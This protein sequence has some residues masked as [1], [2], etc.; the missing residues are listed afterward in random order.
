[1]GYVLN[2]LVNL[3][4][5]EN[6]NFYIFL[7]N[8]QFRDPVYEIVERN[9]M[10]IARSIGDHAVI[11]VGTDKQNFTTSVARKYL[12]EGNSDNS[13]TSLLPALLITNAHPE[14][15]RKDSMR[16]VVPLRDA[17]PRFG[18]WQHFFTLLAQF[19]R[20]ESDEFVRQFEEKEDL[21]DAANKIV[22]LKPGVFGIGL[23]LNA[24]I[25][26]RNRRRH[27]TRAPS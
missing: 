2:K 25:D 5:D 12:G 10:E 15:L 7:V 20:G 6:V 13:F 18:S 24:V 19:A 27:G 4:I 1:M 14:Q 16:L 3:P 8:G 21:L 9:F 11:A 23:N 17:E 26:R 22:N